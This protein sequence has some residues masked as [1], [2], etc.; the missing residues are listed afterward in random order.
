VNKQSFGELNSILASTPQSAGALEK[1]IV[2]S[3]EAQIK[4]A[5][6]LAQLSGGGATTSKNYTGISKLFGNTKEDL[7]HP[8]G[9]SSWEMETASAGYLYDQTKGKPGLENLNGE[10]SGQIMDQLNKAGVGLETI[11]K[12]SPDL[13]KSFKEMAARRLE[14]QKQVVE[15]RMVASGG[16]REDIHK[17]LENFKPP[18]AAETLTKELFGELPADITKMGTFIVAQTAEQIKANAMTVALTDALTNL[19]S[20][21]E[22]N[23]NPTAN[24]AGFAANATKPEAP[25]PDILNSALA[26]GGI[27]TAITSGV[28]SAVGSSLTSKV[29]GMFGKTAVAPVAGAAGAAGG[30]EVAA[31]VVGGA[32]VA[33]GVVG[34]TEVAAGAAA[35]GAEV[36][37]AAGLTTVLGTIAAGLAAF[38]GGAAVGYGIYPGNRTQP[39]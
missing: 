13:A 23:Q 28:V 14:K 7:L 30:A 15:D 9:K 26:G 33:A 39:E 3:L 21:I 29:L 24:A 36:A 1:T 37:A 31:G 10:A 2:K 6:E 12:Y 4:K 19:R 20:A 11:E 32:E 25:K 16:K 17:M 8:A 38:A 5:K 22:K 27:I 18:D 34:G 35:G